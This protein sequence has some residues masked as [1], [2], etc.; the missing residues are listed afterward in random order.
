MVFPGVLSQFPTEART[1]CRN[2][3]KYR[4]KMAACYF[5]FV[6]IPVGSSAPAFEMASLQTEQVVFA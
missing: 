6:F 3:R 5:Y 2:R 4:L 1:Q